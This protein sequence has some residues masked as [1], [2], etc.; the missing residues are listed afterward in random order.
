MGIQAI[1]VNLLVLCYPREAVSFRGQ[2]RRGVI[3]GY[4]EDGAP[5]EAVAELFV[6]EALGRVVGMWGCG[7]V[8]VVPHG[9]DHRAG[10]GARQHYVAGCFGGSEA[11][12]GV[13]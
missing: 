7:F 13:A 6:R 12:E 9:P 5:L 10:E 11:Q 3:V 2:V 4:A 8:V 1:L